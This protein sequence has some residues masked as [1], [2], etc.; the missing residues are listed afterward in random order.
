MFLLA[1]FLSLSCGRFSIT[2]KHRK[3]PICLLTF[4]LLLKSASM[5][6]ILPN[7]SCIGKTTRNFNWQH[8]TTFMWIPLPKIVL[9]CSVHFASDPFLD[10]ISYLRSIQKKEGTAQSHHSLPLLHSLW[11]I[12]FN[13]FFFME[14]M[15]NYSQELFCI[16]VVDEITYFLRSFYGFTSGEP[17]CNQTRRTKACVSKLRFCFSQTKILIWTH[18]DNHKFAPSELAFPGAASPHALC[19]H[20]RSIQSD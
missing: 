7:E 4:L 10:Q 3:I 14:T 12:I 6:G 17:T 2:Q 11:R 15:S 20:K 8:V 18:G 9:L 19:I 13:S 5:Y 16:F 1:I